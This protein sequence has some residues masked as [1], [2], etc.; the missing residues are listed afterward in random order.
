M[1]IDQLYAVFPAASGKFGVLKRTAP[2]FHG[3]ISFTI[4]GNAAE[5]AKSGGKAAVIK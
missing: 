3:A 1:V 5:F 2:Y 4:H